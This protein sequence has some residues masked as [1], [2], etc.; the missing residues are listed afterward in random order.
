MRETLL[1]IP[2][3]RC[4]GSAIPSAYYKSTQRPICFLPAA[5][6]RVVRPKP[7]VLGKE[8]LPQ[9]RQK[10]DN[11]EDCYR[12]HADEKCP[13]AK[14]NI[15]STELISCMDY[16][17]RFAQFINQANRLND[18]SVRVLRPI[19][20]EGRLSNRLSQASQLVKKVA[21]ADYD[22]NSIQLCVEMA[23]S[24]LNESPGKQGCG[25]LLATQ[26]KT[27]HRF[28]QELDAL[29]QKQDSLV[30]SFVARRM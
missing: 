14:S 7:V 25:S 19:G 18:N 29:E 1:D 16:P 20:A 27:M 12:R 9:A 30:R 26:L 23:S 8:N 28:K 15:V 11:P 10:L 5:P 24:V 2:F 17:P 22:G 6:I 13:D 4:G 3:L 21:T